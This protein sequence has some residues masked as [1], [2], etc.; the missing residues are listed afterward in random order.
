MRRAGRGRDKTKNGGVDRK[1]SLQARSWLRK[2][3]NA[4]T[5]RDELE[6]AR[7]GN[8]YVDVEMREEDRHFD[9]DR[10]RRREETRHGHNDLLRGR[11]MSNLLELKSIEMRSRIG[12]TT[13]IVYQ[14]MSWVYQLY[15]LSL[16]L[17]VL[18]LFTI[19]LIHFKRCGPARLLLISLSPLGQ[20]LCLHLITVFS[21]FEDA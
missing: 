2:R 8:R 4:K 16:F 1:R 21:L 13:N 15:L 11:G 3:I 7:Q 18:R 20:Q 6:E 12:I 10:H 5:G 9:R 14:Q 17:V 19:Y